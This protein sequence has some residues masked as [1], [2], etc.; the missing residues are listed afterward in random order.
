MTSMIAKILIL[1]L[2]ACAATVASAQHGGGDERRFDDPEEWAARWD[3]PEREQWQRPKIV[4][5][6]LGVLDGQDVADLG[7]GTGYFT[8]MLANGVGADGTVYVVDIEQAMIDHVM[9]R[10]DASRLDNL[11]P[12]L[13][14]PDDPKLPPA[15][16]DMV[17]T[18]NTWH[19]IGDRVAYLGTLRAALRPGGRLVIVDWRAIERPVGPPAD[20]AVAR[21]TAIEEARAAGWTLAGESLALPYQYILILTPVDEG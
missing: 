1:A 3:T 5:N 2:A 7:A 12:V 13:A 6:L 4:A 10:E 20:H 17:F 8:P 21:E 15:S 19:H 18:C 11:V 9:A 14:A 16:V